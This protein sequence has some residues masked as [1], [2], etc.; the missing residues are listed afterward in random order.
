M[1]SLLLESIDDIHKIVEEQIDVCLEA[2]KKVDIILL[3]GGFCANP[4]LARSLQRRFEQRCEE[5]DRHGKSRKVFNWD[6]R[7]IEPA[8]SQ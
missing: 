6:M 2:G 5:A 4:I 8:N 1:N 3:T 7:I